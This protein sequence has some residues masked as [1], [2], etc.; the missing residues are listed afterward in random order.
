MK[1]LKQGIFARCGSGTHIVS[2]RGPLS[3]DLG[4]GFAP[5]GGDGKQPTVELAIV[6]HEAPRRR[7]PR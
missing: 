7:S 5:G 4:P 1:T 6:R 3:A 2:V